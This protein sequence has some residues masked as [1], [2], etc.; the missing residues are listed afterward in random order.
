MSDTILDRFTIGQGKILPVDH[1]GPAS[2]TTGG[3][4]VGTLNNLTG[5]ALLGLDSIDTI[6]GAGS[7][8]MSGNYT[9]LVQPIGTGVRKQFKIKWLN[10]G[11]TATLSPVGST[12]ITAAGTYTG[13]TPSVTFSAAPAGGVTATGVAIL[14]AAG[15]ALVGILVT[16]PGLYTVGSP[17]TITIGAGGGTA[18]A[19]LAT[20]ASTAGTEVGS[21][22]NLSAE[23]VRLAYVGK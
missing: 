18:T 2:Y 11:G 7:L 17:P 16:N 22:T 5:I 13:T 3:E 21:G 12:T 23:T 8:S 10:S 1:T 4:T 6:Q 15:T 20:A 14:N 9:V 19:A